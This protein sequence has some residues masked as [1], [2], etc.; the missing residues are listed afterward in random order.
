MSSNIDTTTLF[1][2]QGIDVTS[3][4]NQL[5]TAARAPETNWQGQQ[6]TIQTQVD[7]LTQLND[8][9][10]DL[11]EKINS[12]KDPS[13]ATGSVTTSTSNPNLVTATAASGTTPGTHVI[14]VD[15]LA[16][17]SSYYTDPVAS[18]TTTL[19]AGSFTLQVGSG[20][21]ATVTI[22]STDTLTTLAAKVNNLGLDVSASVV[23]DA[24]G[25]RLALVAKNSGAADDLTVGAPSGLN[26]TKAVTGT[27][28]SLTVDGVPISSASNI[29]S[30][31]VP[32]A[33]FT[34]TGASVGTQVSIG[35]SPNTDDAVSAT[36]D[37]VTAYNKVIGELNDGFAYNA[38]TKTGGVLS[39]DSS[40][41]M[42]QESLLS[43]A[44]MN[45]SGSG[46]I[47]TLRS[48]GIDMN[49][50]GTLTVDSTQLNDA[51]TNHFS[52]FQNF[53]QSAS[54]FGQ[55]VSTQLLQLSSPTQGAF[56]LDIKG[57]QTTQSSL[58]SQ[59][60]DFEVYIAGQQQQWLDQ[61]N[62][63]NVMLQQLPLLQSQISA[64]LGDNSSSS[65]K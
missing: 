59:I 34:L 4:V 13:G 43:Y 61:Y 50:D 24:N 9:L 60:D 6:Q 64:E 53:F 1:S 16:T 14:E 40:A 33:T 56:S 38:G 19:N 63:I 49:N 3:V 47:S 65:N 11:W 32:G 42:V 62:Q 57:L 48:L 35:I 7:A 39:G 44:T 37:F 30:G 51:V 18:K 25:A 2:G 15:S 55:T 41:R 17:T 5:V 29:V 45:I 20:T 21:A 27:N 28:A 54:G 58:Q 31:V 22:D 8:D 36:N 52:D 46:S 10:S 12:L 26:F 23:T